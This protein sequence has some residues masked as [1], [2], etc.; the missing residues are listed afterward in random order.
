VGRKEGKKRAQAR[1][2]KSCE[3]GAVTN[4]KYVRPNLETEG[5][6]GFREH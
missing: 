2:E 1:I 5:E 4:V 6:R 3:G